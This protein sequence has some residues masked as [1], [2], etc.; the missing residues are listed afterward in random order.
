MRRRIFYIGL[1]FFCLFIGA[2]VYNKIYASE[3]YPNG[4]T[5]RSVF[6]QMWNGSYKFKEYYD[7]GKLKKVYFTKN[8]KFEGFCTEYFQTG[9]LNSVGMYENGL[10][11]GDFITYRR[12]G[13]LFVIN[14]YLEGENY[15]RKKYTYNSGG[16]L[17][18]S[19]ST[20]IPIIID[21]KRDTIYDSIYFKIK[22]I[23]E[24]LDISCDS[25]DLFYELYEYKAPDGRFPYTPSNIVSLRDCDVQEIKLSTRPDMILNTDKNPDSLYFFVMVRDKVK[26]KIH[27]N[28][29]II[30]PMK[31]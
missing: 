11:K 4:K 18:D 5:K 22:V 28:D 6:F 10:E 12:D 17:V 15:Y 21:Q 2:K 13:K 16:R 14:K 24:G 7:D 9:E 25:L 1:I 23:N 27:E 3:N 26:G 8:D 29:A 31:W 30:I 20:I 19:A